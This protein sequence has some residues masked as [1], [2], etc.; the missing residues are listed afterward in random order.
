[1]ANTFKR[2]LMGLS[3]PPALATYLDVNGAHFAYDSSG[4]VSGLVG[5]TGTTIPLGN[6]TVIIVT[7]SRSLANTDNVSNL[8]YSGASDINLTVPAGLVDYFSCLGSQLG[9]GKMTFLASGT[10]VNNINGFTKTSGQYAQVSL[11]WVSTNAYLLS[12]SAA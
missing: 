5:P 6:A 10:T 3:M 12:G 9:A 8:V 2:D 4:N 7:G 11:S 1:M